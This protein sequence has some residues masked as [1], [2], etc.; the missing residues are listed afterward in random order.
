MRVDITED[1]PLTGCTGTKLTFQLPMFLRRCLYIAFMNPKEN[2][3]Q[4]ILDA[5]AKVGIIAS[6]LQQ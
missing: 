2:D 3:H 4:Q 1:E 5:V 6:N